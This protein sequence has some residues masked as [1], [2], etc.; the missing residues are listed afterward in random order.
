MNH[1]T[2]DWYSNVWKTIWG[3]QLIDRRIGM[4]QYLSIKKH[5]IKDIANRCP[6]Y[7]V[8]KIVLVD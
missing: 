5:A 7:L 6:I 2:Q 1:Y 4:K 8:T 3:I